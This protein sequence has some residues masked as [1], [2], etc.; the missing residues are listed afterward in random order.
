MAVCGRHR[1]E[2]THQTGKSNRTGAAPDWKPHEQTGPLDF[3]HDCRSTAPQLMSYKT[4]T[5]VPSNIQNGQGN[6]DFEPSLPGQSWR[7]PPAKNIG[8]PSK[9]HGDP[10]ATM[11]LRQDVQK[12]QET[13]KA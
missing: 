13:V 2:R 8:D 12:M 1:K 4:D 3:D 7:L 9:S 5:K 11:K 10:G 6:Q